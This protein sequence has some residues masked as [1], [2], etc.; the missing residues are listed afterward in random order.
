MGRIAGKGSSGPGEKETW[1]TDVV[2]I[3]LCIVSRSFVPSLGQQGL[4]RCHNNV[5]LVAYRF[6]VV[7]GILVF[8]NSSVRPIL[9]IPSEAFALIS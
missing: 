7:F 3:I 9:K 5:P 8:G 4:S 2:L 6:G 1:R